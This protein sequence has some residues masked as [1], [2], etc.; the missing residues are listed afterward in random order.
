MPQERVKCGL[1]VQKEYCRWLGEAGA[2]TLMCLNHMA[3]DVSADPTP[4][5]T[6]KVGDGRLPGGYQ[7]PPDNLMIQLGSIV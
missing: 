6:L 2:P 7:V 1:D 3:R 5:T 4:S